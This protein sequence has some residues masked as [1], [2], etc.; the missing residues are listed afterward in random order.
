MDKTD[1]I[2]VQ[3]IHTNAGYLGMQEAIGTADF[4]PNGGTSQPGCIFDWIG[5]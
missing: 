4:Y 3:V 1:A 2:L 5:K